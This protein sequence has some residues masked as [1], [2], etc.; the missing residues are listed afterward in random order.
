MKATAEGIDQ[1]IFR[2]SIAPEIF[3][4]TVRDTLWNFNDRRR[5]RR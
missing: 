4:R 2:K 3:Y 5:S 1:G